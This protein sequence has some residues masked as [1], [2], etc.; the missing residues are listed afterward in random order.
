MKFF[1]QLLLFGLAAE[2]TVANNRF[3]KAGTFEA[4]NIL[5]SAY[6]SFQ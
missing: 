1:S 4:F 3:S 6:S 2:A 5:I